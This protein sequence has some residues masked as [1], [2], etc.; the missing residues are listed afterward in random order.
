MATVHIA[1]VTVPIGSRAG[2]T[3]LPDA[4][5]YAQQDITSS[6]SSQATTI[7]CP[8][9]AEGLYAWSVTSY[10]GAVR[11]TA[12]AAPTATAATGWI[13]PDG[14]TREFAAKGGQKLA[15]INA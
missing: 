12:G 2:I 9:G 3:M 10:G 15:V 5:P 14:Q 6:G 4:E 1:L 13:V 7:A 8:S 11:L